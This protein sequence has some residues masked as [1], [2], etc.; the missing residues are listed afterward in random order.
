MEGVHIAGLNVLRITDVICLPTMHRGKEL[1]G[2]LNGAFLCLPGR[3]GIFKL[4]AEWFM[5]REGNPTEKTHGAEMR[6]N[7]KLN[8]HIASTPG[9]EPGLYCWEATALSTAPYLLFF[10]PVNCSRTRGRPRNSWSRKP[11]K[12]AQEALSESESS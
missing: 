8:Q 3:I 10:G 4:K 5:W 7:N 1:R 11:G 2:S 6:T 9:I 12:G